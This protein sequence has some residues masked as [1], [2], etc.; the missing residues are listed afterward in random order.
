MKRPQSKHTIIKQHLIQAIQL[1]QFKDRLPSENELAGKFAVSR[2]TARK[3]LIELAHEGVVK[4]VQGSGTFIRKPDFA[5][6]YFTIQSSRKQAETL[7]VKHATEVLEV[8][9][10]SDPSEDV[11]R[12]LNDA[13][14]IIRVRRI[15]FYDD[16]PVRYEIRHLRGDL[17]AGILWENLQEA[18]IHDLLVDKYGLP[19]TKAWQKITAV[20]MPPKIAALFKE[21]VGYPAFYIERI[22]YTYEK[23][24]TLVEY[25]IRGEVAFED[26]FSPAS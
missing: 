13:R 20:T 2:M 24:V 25:Y 12:K 5:T 6:S 19:L 11:V 26:E 23:P 17:C 8:R 21:P 18:S 15:H 7:K 10:V 16:K 1:R 9:L 14:Q 4:R 22:T 3:V